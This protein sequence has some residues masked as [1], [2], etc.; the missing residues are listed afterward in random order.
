MPE[1]RSPRALGALALVMVGLS[2]LGGCGG[3][4]A[5]TTATTATTATS[6]SGGEASRDDETF[7]L[8]PMQAVPGTGVSMRAPRGSEPT[9]FGSGFVHRARRVQILVAAAHGGPEIIAAFRRGIELEAESVETEEVQ[10]AG[11]TTTLHIDRQENGDIVLERVWVLLVDGERAFVIA[12]AYDSERSERVRGLVRASVLTA[13]WDTAQE[14][15]PEVAVGFRLTAPE[16][17]VLDRS[18]TGSVTYGREGQIMPPV[19]GAPTLFLVAIPAAIPLAQRDEA[20]EPI[21][22]QA[23]PVPDDHV[24]TR[25]RIETETVEGC[26]VTGFQE[27]EA[28]D[29]T[30]IALATYAAVVYLGDDTFMIAGVVAEPERETWL[31]RFA[32]AARSV[33]SAR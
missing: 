32:E 31:A 1:Q 4:A 10:I 21:L 5:Q 28:E 2:L 22:A 23:G 15:D 27:N 11:R 7:P 6:A 14:L 3:R 8:D 25:G 33:T 29:G 30:T 16:G 17:L 26:E 20:C 9:P 12:G 24:R 18:T 13:D 19:M